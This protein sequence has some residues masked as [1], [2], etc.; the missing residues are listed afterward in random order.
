MIT[1]RGDLKTYDS[2]WEI[3]GFTS[4]RLI[5]EGNNQTQK[6][7][8]IKSN[9]T[10][11]LQQLLKEQKAV[12]AIK[13]STTLKEDTLEA[14]NSIKDTNEGAIKLKQLIKN[15]FDDIR[16]KEIKAISTH[17]TIAEKEALADQYYWCSFKKKTGEPCNKAKATP[18]GMYNHRIDCRHRSRGDHTMAVVHTG[19]IGTTKEPYDATFKCIKKVPISDKV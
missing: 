17:K 18:K 1:K 13:N 19:N 3:D 5:C 12:D 14:I 15:I 6:S 2:C 7:N 16:Y 9:E 4:R 11:H 8:I 10:K